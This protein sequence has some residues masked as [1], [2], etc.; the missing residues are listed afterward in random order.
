MQFLKTY[1]F[2]WLIYSR[3][4]LTLSFASSIVMNTKSSRMKDMQSSRY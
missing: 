2:Q 1:Y 3:F 4:I